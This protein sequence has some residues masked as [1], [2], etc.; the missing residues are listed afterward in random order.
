MDEFN[1][2]DS[3][4]SKSSSPPGDL[5][6]TKAEQSTNAST[7]S[8]DARNIDEDEL[9]AGEL[10]RAIATTVSPPNIQSNQQATTLLFS[11]IEGRC[12]SQARSYLNSRRHQQ[13]QLSEDDAEVLALADSIFKETLTGMKKAGL[14]PKEVAIPGAVERRDFLKALDTRLKDIAVHEQPARNLTYDT[15][16]N[17]ER[18]SAGDDASSLFERSQSQL[19]PRSQVNYPLRIASGRLSSSPLDTLMYPSGINALHQESPYYRKFRE[20]CLLGKG[21][22]GQVFRARHNLDDQEYAI[23]QI[24]VSASQLRSIHDQ[25]QLEHLLKEL[26]ALA[27]L[28]HRNV[29]RYYDSWCELRPASWHSLRTGQRLL[30]NGPDDLR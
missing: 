23:K 5:S 6:D 28:Q 12:K 30:E 9:V 19:Q 22:F 11:L 21:G 17:S 4:T 27:K 26:R 7:N 8:L 3:T 16:E 18:Y 25:V 10:I 2:P 20:I 14:I 13:D 24:R 15:F 29:V 1:K